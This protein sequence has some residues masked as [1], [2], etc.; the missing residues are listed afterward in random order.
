MKESEEN[1]W[2][3]VVDYE[4]CVYDVR[5]PEGEVVRCWPNAGFFND[6][7]T[8]QDR[9][10]EV[11]TVEAKVSDDWWGE[12]Q[13]ADAPECGTNCTACGYDREEEREEKIVVKRVVSFL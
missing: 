1:D 9:R 11:G 10:W 6:I 5:T 13:Q 8:K 12:C 2:S 3:V 4:K 7:E